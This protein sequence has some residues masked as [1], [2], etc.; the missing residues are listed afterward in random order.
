MGTVNQ[1]AIM[2]WL[3][4]QARQLGWQGLLGLALLIISAALVL[5]W[6]VPGNTCLLYTSDAADE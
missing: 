1:H 5:G 4:Y 6:L 3:Q 2:A